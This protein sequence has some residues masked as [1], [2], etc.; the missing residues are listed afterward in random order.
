MVAWIKQGR[1]G[2][3]CKTLFDKIFTLNIHFKSTI[4]QRGAQ[5]HVFKSDQACR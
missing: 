4:I 3:I 2:D 1:R 5:K